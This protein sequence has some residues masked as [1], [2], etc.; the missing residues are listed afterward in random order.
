MKARSVRVA[1][2]LT[3]PLG[4]VLC[5]GCASAA[6]AQ[7]PSS[8]WHSVQALPSQTLVRITAAGSTE[9]CFIDAVSDDR[10]ACSSRPSDTGAHHDFTRDQVTSIRL[11]GHFSAAAA[12]ITA[13][14]FTAAG[15][16]IGATQTKAYSSSAKPIGV[17]AAGGLGVGVVAGVLVGRAVG[18]SHGP[19]I[20]RR[21]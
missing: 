13:A 20:Y 19:I 2:R 3:L 9:T 6:S 1:C 8:D 18:R 15:A 4:L 7:A 10:I 16:G 17:G 5:A 12:V 11:T 14:A 21:P